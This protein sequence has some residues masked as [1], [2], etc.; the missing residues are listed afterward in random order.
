MPPLLSW[1]LP[2]RAPRILVIELSIVAENMHCPVNPA[3]AHL[4]GG[5]SCPPAKNAPS[6]TPNRAQ[7]AV[8]AEPCSDRLIPPVF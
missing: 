3:A 1:S 5:H 4:E 8:R 6:T 2:A 7:S